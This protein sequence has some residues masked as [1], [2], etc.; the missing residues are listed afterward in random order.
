MGT[1][2][3]RKLLDTDRYQQFCDSLVFIEAN[4][5]ELVKMKESK[6]KKQL[7]KSAKK[8]ASKL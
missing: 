4:T 1:V 3:Y 2:K 6:K 7:K 8:L 5:K